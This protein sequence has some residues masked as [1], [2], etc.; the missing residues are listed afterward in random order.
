MK[1]V[2]SVRNFTLNARQELLRDHSGPCEQV[3][4]ASCVEHDIVVQGK[5]LDEI[6][7]RFINA[8]VGHVV[9]ANKYGFEPF[10]SLP[11]G[12][13]EM[14]EADL[15]PTVSF[16]IQA[17]MKRIGYQSPESSV[18]APQGRVTLQVA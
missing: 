5:T 8:V 4:V 10:D 13:M 16:S 11:D 12:C 7:E 14:T 15:T 9:I 18:M 1:P 17:V 3:W 6:Q 2:R